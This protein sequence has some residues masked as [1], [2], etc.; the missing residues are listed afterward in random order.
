MPLLQFH[1]MQIFTNALPQQSGFNYLREYSAIALC[2]DT[3]KGQNWCA[4]VFV[5][6]FREV[7]SAC[8]E[9]GKHINGDDRHFSSW[10]P[11]E[12]KL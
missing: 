8:S 11:S 12:A 6:D 10:N 4:K 1:R 2:E 7:I 9:S 5:C 3:I